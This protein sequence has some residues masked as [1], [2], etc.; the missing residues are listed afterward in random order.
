M[1]NSLTQLSDELAGI[2]ERA[3][4][5]VVAI[6]GGGRV[7][8][9]GVH[10]KPGLIVTAEHSL[11]RDEDLKIGMPD[12][13]VVAAELAGRDPG[14]D[15]ALLKFDAGN[16]PVI[17]TGGETR[18]GDLVVAVG[19][20]REIG[21][22]AALG[23]VSVVGPGWNTWRGGRVDQFVRLDVSLYPGSSGAA[24]V[25]AQGE[26]VGIATSLL[27][28]I[29][30]VAI[31][32]VTVDRVSAELAKRGYVARGYLGVGLQPVPLP[33][34]L[35]TG[36]MIVLSVEKDSP[37]AKAGLVV[38]DIL[39]ALNGHAVKDTRDVQNFLSTDYIGKTVQ[40]AIIRGGQ[41]A[42]LA[43]TIGEK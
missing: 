31:P 34:E 21:V 22:C 18:T 35:G 6:Y 27:S 4:Q 8:S 15:V 14:S 28:R 9:S 30:P 37:A 41:R 17:Q 11:R 39:V 33:E 19:R 36:G 40:T 7:P 12:G 38:G 20:H 23:I 42:E 24:V 2:V 43:L 5:S 3:G 16:L 32:R 29:A 26:A 13:K 25:N 1:P 10:W